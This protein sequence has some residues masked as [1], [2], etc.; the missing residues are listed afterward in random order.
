MRFWIIFIII[1]LNSFSGRLHISFIWSCRFLPCSFVCKS[2][3]CHFIFYSF[4][5]WCCIPIFLFVWPETSSTGV[6]RQLDWAGSWCWN[7]D[8]QEASLWLIFP[9]VWGSLLVQQFGLWAPT[10]VARALLLAWE[11]RSWK[12]CS[13]VKK[14]KK[15]KKKRVVQYQRIKHKI[16]L[17]K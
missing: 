17:E 13:T 5:G 12:V 8:L 6:C 10:A 1:T 3:F 7:E 15:R 2:L 14:F 11:P 4:D 16:K 9:R